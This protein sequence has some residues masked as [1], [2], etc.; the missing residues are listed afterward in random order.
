MMHIE[1]SASLS[2][3]DKYPIGCLVTGAMEALCLNE[4]L[5]EEG[6]VSVAMLPVVWKLPDCH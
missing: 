1:F 2:L 6:T 4:G 3:A 5:E